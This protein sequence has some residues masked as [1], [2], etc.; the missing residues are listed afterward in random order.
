VTVLRGHLEKVD[1]TDILFS[2]QFL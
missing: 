1:T 2:F